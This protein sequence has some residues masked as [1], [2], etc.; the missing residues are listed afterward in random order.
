[1]LGFWIVGTCLLAAIWIARRNSRAGRGDRIG[2]AVIASVSFTAILLRW[3]LTAQHGADPWEI[4]ML[5]RAIA[6]G[7]LVAAGSW[8]SYMA[9]EPYVRRH[10]PDSL[11]SWTRLCKGKLRDPLVA[12]HILAG[13]AVC[14]I[15][16]FMILL[17]LYAVSAPTRGRLPV[18]ALNSSAA[19]AADLVNTVLGALGLAVIY[20]LLIVLLRLLLKRIWIADALASIL[21]ASSGGVDYSDPYRLAVTGPT[22][23]LAVYSVLW[24]MRRFG[25]VAMMA[26]WWLNALLSIV[27]TSFAAWYTGR[28]IVVFAIPIAVAAWALWVIVNA[29]RPTLA[30]TIE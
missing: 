9:I 27:P 17:M 10:W 4:G 23:V 6:F 11:I 24:L 18:G 12:S 29:S 1:V 28:L 22:V 7:L 30:G 21:I 3:L 19:A 14:A 5:L 25:L 13:L 8:I 20:L 2:A 15:A 16:D 26:D